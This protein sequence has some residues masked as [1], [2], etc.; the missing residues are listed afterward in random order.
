MGDDKG[1]KRCSIMY[2]SVWCCSCLHIIYMASDLTTGRVTTMNKN[3]NYLLD[4]HPSRLHC[5]LTTQTWGECLYPENH[6]NIGHSSLAGS[7]GGLQSQPPPREGSVVGSNLAA[8]GFT[9]SGHETP[10]RM[11]TDQPP[12]A[13]A[14]LLGCPHGE[15]TFQINSS[16]FKDFQDNIMVGK[17]PW[18]QKSKIFP[19]P[20][21]QITWSAKIHKANK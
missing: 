12:W 21:K 2:V 20:P 3:H 14:P 15:K 9:K 13:P 6:R 11:E 16:S 7:W 10:S 5:H 17:H 4:C 1:P 8:Q 18:Q 19:S